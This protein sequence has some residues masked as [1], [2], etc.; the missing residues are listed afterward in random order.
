MANITAVNDLSDNALRTYVCGGAAASIAPMVENYRKERIPG[1]A[2]IAAIYAD[3]SRSDVTADISDDHIYIFPDS[4][5]GS[6]GVKSTNAGPI[7]TH[8]LALLDKHKPTQTSVV[9]CSA[10]GGT[11]N[12]I[13][14]SIVKELQERDVD[15]ILIMIGSTESSTRINNT[16][17]SLQ[18]MEKL[19]KLSNRPVCQFYFENSEETPPSK[20]DELVC[21]AMA[22]LAVVFSRQ[23][24]SLD[25]SDL[26]SL[27]NFN[28]FKD[29]PE[30]HLAGLEIV[31]G[32]LTS[33]YEKA[34]RVISVCSIVDNLDN[35]GLQIPVV[36]DC[37]GILPTDAPAT[38]LNRIPFHLV[39][40][41]YPFNE[42]A[43]R[44]DKRK[45]E[46]ASAA[47]S[48]VKNAGVLSVGDQ[49]DSDDWLVL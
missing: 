9:L 23:N 10:S 14:A 16:L 44:L 17:G 32:P 49:G 11:G 22:T 37:H 42:I 41:S 3:T 48:R 15:V 2:A 29:A 30:A 1:L 45:K 46:I 12:V 28:R 39:T 20:V 40:V 13:A 38:V 47:A 31:E 19:V 35:R 7:R 33:D 18:T 43:A 36:Y 4:A 24:K 27:L 34:D 25:R 5:D 26:R 6:G 21:R 8:T